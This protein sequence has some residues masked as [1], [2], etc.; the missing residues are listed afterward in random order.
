M[1]RLCPKHGEP[2]RRRKPSGWYCRCCN[3]EAQQRW[4]ATPHG[5]AK[6]RE[7]NLA[8][9]G[10]TGY[11]DRANATAR[12]AGAKRRE[13]LRK[14]KHS[15]GCADCGYRESVDGLTFDHVPERG[16]KLFNISTKSSVSLARL[17]LELEKCDVVCG[18][19][20]LIR[21]AT[22]R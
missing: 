6:I 20:H 8:R 21:T 19:C 12:R 17:Q 16:P 1:I 10:R 15:S 11:Q 4:R 14:I 13:L 2:M 22:R 3:T 9:K 18:T 7:L 5:A